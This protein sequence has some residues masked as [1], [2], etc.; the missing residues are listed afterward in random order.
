MFSAFCR[1][2]FKKHFSLKNLCI[3]FYY[4]IVTGVLHKDTSYLIKL[5]PL[6]ISQ[7]KSMM[8]SDNLYELCTTG[9]SVSA[10]LAEDTT[11]S[12]AEAW[13]R[14]CAGEHTSIS[15]GSSTHSTDCA[16]FTNEDI[17]RAR[18]CGNWG[19]TKPSDLFLQVR[20]SLHI[21]WNS[22]TINRFI[23]MHSVL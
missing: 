10:L 2:F 6:E 9:K 17:R 21:C 14:L 8:I 11:Q 12:P 16:T 18:E 3:V 15:N 19:P 23:T 22:L 13:D 4:I 7:M 5:Q 20:W 1:F